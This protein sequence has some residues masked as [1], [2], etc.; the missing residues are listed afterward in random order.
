MKKFTKLFLSCAA[1][2]AV[3]AA[4][5]TS[6]MAA[7]FAVGAT[8]VAPTEEGATAA[9]VTIDA[10]A[11]QAT[12]KTLLILNKD[13]DKTAITQDDILQIMQDETITSAVVPVLVEGT[14]D[15][16]YVVLMGG[17]DGKI[18]EG[19]FRIGAVSGQEY[20]IGDASGDGQI[21]VND[22]TA[23]LNYGV[24]ENRQKDTGKE[25]TLSDGSSIG[26]NSGDIILVGDASNDGQILVNDATAILNYNVNTNRQKETGK[27]VTGT[28][29]E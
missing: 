19:S 1:V 10:T 15:G 20:I 11:S 21:L 3:T 12:T 9:S 6:A 16:T 13:A 14:D 5:A 2:T 17:D 28:M 25:I 24:N 22:A 23:I 29:A 27:V 26:K 7:D 8:Y 18:G 4:V